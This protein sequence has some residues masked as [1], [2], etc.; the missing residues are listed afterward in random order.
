[1]IGTQECITI[2]GKD[3]SMVLLYTTLCIYRL[4]IACFAG[5]LIYWW[6]GGVDYI[7]FTIVGCFILLMQLN[8]DFTGES[9]AFVHLFYR[10]MFLAVLFSYLFL[11]FFHGMNIDK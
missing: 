10:G 8:A 11:T 4:A 1:M 5:L 9:N 2:K 6:G 3:D 7:I